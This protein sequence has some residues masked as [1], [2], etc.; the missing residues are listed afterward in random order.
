MF[1]NQ[2]TVTRVQTNPNLFKDAIQ[3]LKL[4]L[5]Y[6]E[7]NKKINTWDSKKYSSF[8]ALL[9][10]L[11]FVDHLGIVSK[12]A[13]KNNFLINGHEVVGI[14]VDL[15]AIRLYLLLTCIDICVGKKGKVGS[16]FKNAIGNLSQV[17]REQL[18]KNLRVSGKA[19]IADIAMCFYSLRCGFTHNGFRFLYDDKCPF[20]QLQLTCGDEILEI[21]E[22]FDLFAV[23]QDVVAE[24]ACKRFGLK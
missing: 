7:L 15:R 3:Y 23:L 18:E 13:L 17:V 2:F 5:S 10:R 16:K 1:R 14:D 19:N 24:I 12:N 6:E 9:D 4:N 22:K 11:E 8:N 21:E 20:S